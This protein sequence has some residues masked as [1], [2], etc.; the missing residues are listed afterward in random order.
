MRKEHQIRLALFAIVA[1]ACVMVVAT[2]QA[3]SAADP[4]T[5]AGIGPRSLTMLLN[6][7]WDSDLPVRDK[8]TIR[9]TFDLGGAQR[10]LELDNVNGNIEIVGTDS[11]QVQLVVNKTIRAKSD[12]KL[13]QARREV[14]LDIKQNGGTLQLYVD[15]PFRC[16]CGDRRSV[17]FERHPGY[18]VRM[19]FELQV[20]RNINLEV[21]TV[22]EGEVRIR[23]VRGAYDVRNVNGGIEMTRVAGSG[24]AHTVNG[25]VKVTFTENPREQSSFE[26]INGNIELYFARGLSADFRF[27][28]FN[29]AIYSDFPVTSLPMRTVSE[30]RKGR[31]VVFRADR[32]TGG[33]VGSGGAEIRVENLNGDIRILENQQ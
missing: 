18:S 33:R 20:P 24:S 1:L 8:E 14:T 5:F 22:N 15:G 30:E 19:D 31:K 23:E 3:G 28:N 21:S 10:S 25:G 29:G 7:D 13:E 12:A 27:K 2:V 6:E 32:F 9:Q 11:N 16:R 26:S 17:N 4:W